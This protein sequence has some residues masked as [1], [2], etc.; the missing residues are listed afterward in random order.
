MRRFVPRALLTAAVTASAAACAAGAAGT[1]SQSAEGGETGGRYRVLVPEL[2]GPNGDRVADRLRDLISELPTHTAVP[3]R[4][5]KRAMGQYKLESLDEI[6]SRQLAQQISAENVLW[7]EISQGGAGLEADIKF[8]DVRSGDEILIEDVS[9]ADAGA[10]AQAVYA[11]LQQKIEGIRKAAFCNDYLSSQQ[12]E[13]A[14]ENCEEAL[15]VVPTS[16]SAL[17][18][19]ATALLNLERYPESLEVYEQLLAIDPA[20][21]DGLLGAGLAASRLEQSDRAMGYYTRY[22][23]VNPGN[24]QVRMTVANDI[25]KTGD[26]VSAFHLLEP[27]VAENADNVDFQKY[28]F[29]VATAAGQ[30]VEE[31]QG[32]EAARPFYLAAQ[33]AYNVAFA[34][35]DQ[36]L[37]V[38]TLRAV[39]AVNNALGEQAEALRL[40]QEATQ[41]HDTVASLWSLYASVLSDA[42]QHGEEA[43]ALSRVA[44]LDPDYEN[45][46]IRRGYALLRAGQRQQALQDLERAA[47]RGNRE[48]VAKVLYSSGAQAY[49]ANRYGEA[50]DALSLANQY[51]AGDVKSKAQFL[52]GVSYYR[53]A[54]AIAKANTQGRAGEAQKALDLFQKALPFLQ[55]TGEPQAA[56][57]RTAAQ[58]YIENQQAIIKASSRGR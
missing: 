13:R 39:I 49:Q 37:D 24:V 2:A 38:G 5:L 28:F 25:A 34:A 27:V 4:D 16:G 20:H 11:S 42:G 1:G 9:G 12:F 7:G 51:A 17:Y 47:N 36:E 58:Q 33:N 8:V 18:G 52:L 19:K 26:F 41:A 29:S 43:R 44:E 3:E 23:E 30:R 56:Q 53:Q 21:Q 57:V 31:Q 10:L 35:G 40:A 50:I 45:V 15:A 54:E 6:T 22:M 46:Y 48:D 32:D 14:L 55:A